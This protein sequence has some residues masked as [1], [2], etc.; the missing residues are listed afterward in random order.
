MEIGELA[1]VLAAARVIDDRIM[2]NEAMLMMWAE[3]IPPWVSLE[4]GLQAVKSHY[5]N[6][7]QR[8]MPNHLIDFAKSHRP[9]LPPPPV[10][11]TCDSMGVIVIYER[12]EQGI[13]HKVSKWCHC[14]NK[15]SK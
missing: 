2:V 13:E 8:F 5:T 3:L 14:R 10:C 1:R 15:H 11:P 12:D 9:Q 6:S 4:T 7:A